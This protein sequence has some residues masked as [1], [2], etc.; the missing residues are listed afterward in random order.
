MKQGCDAFETLISS[1]L[2]G[3]LTPE[4]A[5]ACR[6]HV[7]SCERCHDLGERMGG[8][9][10][11][12]RATPSP[13][14]PQG[15]LAS[16][17]ADAEREMRRHDRVAAFWSR[18]R[19]S[20]A[21]AAAAAAVLL[22]VVAS[23]QMKG[24][25]QQMPA[26]AAIEQPTVAVAEPEPSVDAAI[27][28]AEVEAEEAQAVV[29]P[30][31]AIAAAPPVREARPTIARAPEAASRADAV[32]EEVAA[33]VP[34]AQPEEVAAPTEPKLAFAPPAA[35][36][37]AEPAT[38]PVLT[39]PRA[40]LIAEA[41]RT[42][43]DSEAALAPAGPSPLELE[44]A[45]S[46]VARMVVDKFI[47]DHMVETPATLLSVV[48]DTPTSEL[49]RVVTEEVENGGFGLSFTDAMRRALSDK[50]NQLP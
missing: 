30:E 20:T 34:A 49:G 10:E 7:D 23:Q 39:Q 35:G 1:S 48:T 17:K 50:E 46:V 16:I 44:L 19:V 28:E 14:A 21:I 41:P 11:V 15:L 5:D 36:R 32:R 27:A 18:W 37:E 6:R 31:P 42:T 29:V 13:E 40:A 12:L 45:S 22:I 26:T 33:E 2:D 4:E 38:E 9:R 24:P 47:A 25:E 8:V 43:L 3:Q